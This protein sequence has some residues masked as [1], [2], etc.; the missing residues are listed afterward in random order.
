MLPLGTPERYVRNPNLLILDFRGSGEVE[1]VEGVPIQELRDALYQVPLP[2][3]KVT[4]RYPYATD[5]V[6]CLKTIG[7]V[8]AYDFPVSDVP[9]GA[10]VKVGRSPKASKKGRLIGKDLDHM[11][12]LRWGTVRGWPLP[13]KPFSNPGPDQVN[14]GLFITF[15]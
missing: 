12:R 7:E 13:R 1:E 15:I 8:V 2:V 6:V 3:P 5:L 10:P 14:K 11:R 4:F 9:L